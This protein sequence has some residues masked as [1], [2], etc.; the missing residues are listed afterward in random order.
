MRQA[1]E[2][3]G[4]VSGGRPGGDFYDASGA[5]GGKT[6]ASTRQPHGSQQDQVEK[7]EENWR[8]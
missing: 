3:G 8:K 1:A 6:V 2:G 5:G 7:E 4:D